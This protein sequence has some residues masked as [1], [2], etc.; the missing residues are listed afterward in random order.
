MFCFDLNSDNAR[1]IRKD[2]EGVTH[3]GE[4]RS[5]IN[6]VLIFLERE[7][8]DAVGKTLSLRRQTQNWRS[9]TLSRGYAYVDARFA[10]LL[11]ACWIMSEGT[12]YFT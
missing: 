9:M 6:S 11:P 10:L 1:L 3:V 2:G 5:I 12:S 4:E 7:P 8:V